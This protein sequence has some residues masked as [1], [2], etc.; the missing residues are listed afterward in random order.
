MN[1]S[2]NIINEK[3]CNFNKQSDK[4]FSNTKFTTFHHFFGLF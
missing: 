3:F 1:I 2:L 4:N